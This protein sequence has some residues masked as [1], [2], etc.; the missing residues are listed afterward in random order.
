MKLMK[1]IKVHPHKIVYES[2]IETFTSGGAYIPALKKYKGK[3][4]VVT[5]LLE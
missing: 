2:T 1:N 3:T 5:I 4:V